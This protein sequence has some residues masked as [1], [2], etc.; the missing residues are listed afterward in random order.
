[1]TEY[2]RDHTA[3]GTHFFTVN[4]SDRRSSGLVDN[5]AF[6]RSALRIVRTKHP[7]RIEAMVVLPEHMH[8]VWTL[9]PGDADYAVRWRLIKTLFSLSMPRGERRSASR[10]TKHERGIWQRRFW[11]HRIRDDRDLA[12]H[13]DYVHINPVKHALVE[14]V[15]D[16]PWSSFH[17]HV[18]AGDLPRDWAGTRELERNGGAFGERR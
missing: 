11:E 13:I 15:C 6:L 4:L 10:R 14:R 8:A 7:F 5:I 1:M 18:R 2:R 16:W 17:R 9:P 12:T 3:G